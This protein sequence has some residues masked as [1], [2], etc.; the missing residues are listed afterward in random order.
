MEGFESTKHLSETSRLSNYLEQ[1]GT[2]IN[3][4][5]AV[6]EAAKTLFGESHPEHEVEEIIQAFFAEQNNDLD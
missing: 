3:D 4:T 2:D 5:E 6:I 1:E